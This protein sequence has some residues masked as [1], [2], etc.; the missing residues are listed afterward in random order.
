MEQAAVP[1]ENALATMIALQEGTIRS[2]YSGTPC[3]LQAHS[4]EQVGF[5]LIGRCPRGIEQHKALHAT[6]GAQ[7]VP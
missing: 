4:G 7:L 6:Y 5:A 2:P 3:R 1:F